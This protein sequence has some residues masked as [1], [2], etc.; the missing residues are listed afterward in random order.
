[1]ARQPGREAEAGDSGDV[2][3]YLRLLE[4]Y[5]QHSDWDEYLALVMSQRFQEDLAAEA[6][7][8]AAIDAAGPLGVLEVALDQAVRLRRIGAAAALT[9]AAARWTRRMSVHTAL[10]AD[11]PHGEA[12]E[13]ELRTGRDVLRALLRAWERYDAGNRGAARALLAAIVRGR[14]PL[15]RTGDGDRWAVPLLR[16]A[17]VIDP[18]AAVL[19]LG[20]VDDNVLGDLARELTAAGDYARARTAGAA[21]RLFFETKAD[22]LADLALAQAEAA[23]KQGTARQQETA[24]GLPLGKPIEPGDRRAVAETANLAADAVRQAQQEE[25]GAS[26]APRVP[27]VAGKLAK[28]AAALTLSGEHALAARRWA[29]AMAAAEQ[30]PDPAEA[31]AEF[32]Q[33]QVRA[34]LLDDA[35]QVIA[36]LLNETDTSWQADAALDPAWQ[37]VTALVA[38]LDPAWQAVTALVAAL[39]ES[40]DVARALTA[41]RMIPDFAHSSPRAVCAVARAIAGTDVA[42]AERLAGLVRD[43]DGR[44]LALASV[45]AA[46]LAAGHQRDAVRVADG[47]EHPGWRAQ[48]LVDLAGAP[49]QAAGIPTGKARDA[50][51]AVTDIEKGAVLLAE[52]AVTQDIGERRRFLAEATRL[53]GKA[54]A[55]ARWRALANIGAIAAQAG[56]TA[57]ARE[58]FTAARRLLARDT[59]EWDFELSQLCRAQ[60]SVGDTTGARETV[61]VTLGALPGPTT[62]RRLWSAVG[63]AITAPASR[64]GR[65]GR[66]SRPRTSVPDPAPDPAIAAAEAAADI[67]IA[68]AALAAIACAIGEAAG[69]AAPGS[70]RAI[71]H[72]ASELDAGDEQAAMAGQVERVLAEAERLAT[73]LRDAGA[74]VADESLAHAYTALG[75]FAAAERRI[76]SLLPPPDPGAEHNAGR[77]SVAADGNVEAEAAGDAHRA[78]P[79]DDCADVD[80]NA[81]GPDEAGDEI[82]LITVALE[83]SSALTD[84]LVAAGEAEHAARFM[85]EVA[86]RLSP[87]A[88]RLGPRGTDMLA[89]LAAAQV[90]AG[91]SEG[92]QTTAAFAATMASATNAAFRL[93]EPLGLP[94]AD[95]TGTVAAVVNEMTALVRDAGVGPADFAGAGQRAGDYARRPWQARAR[96]L[97]ALA[98]T[99]A[100][101]AERARIAA[102]L[103]RE[104]QQIWQLAT[105]TFVRG[106]TLE[107]GDAA[108]ALAA[109]AGAQ[110]RIGE[111]ADA[112]RAIARAREMAADIE[113]SAERAHALAE[114]ALSLSAIGDH[115]AAIST[116]RR[117]D[118]PAY[119]GQAIAAAITAAAKAGV[120]TGSMDLAGEARTIKDEGWRAIALAG[121]ALAGASPLD[122]TEAHELIRQVAH[123]NPRSQAWHEIIGLCLAT[124]RYDLAVGLTDEITDDAGG[125]LAVIAGTLGIRASDAGQPPGGASP[126]Q[127]AA[128]QEAAGDALLRLLPRCARYPE[129]AYAACTALAMAFPADATVIAG[130]VAQHAAAVIAATGDRGRG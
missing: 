88:W 13:A 61:A 21:M 17:L 26:M 65:A 120:A 106:A 51:A 121:V 52:Y 67:P 73:G 19:L 10:R 117:I 4:L 31:L 58:A 80:E 9:L 56:L 96:T 32:A 29:E 43:P 125:H 3:R 128:E 102:L 30:E 1:M 39:A 78:D 92:A 113:H 105:V 44:G 114:V 48:A 71:V 15:I 5:K 95:E 18:G 94:M 84:A 59:R 46:A 27:R 68:V 40:G 60:L 110:A 119:Q 49:E 85:R 118:H 23:L 36:V 79:G 97:A 99:R 54:P 16:Q 37:G 20:L 50:I 90:R 82:R 76:L 2:S 127:N 63:A 104:Q 6:V 98:R 129:A 108:C 72:Q 75:H 111:L 116:A 64:R 83:C 107:P 86:D 69:S 103:A 8:T 24:V 22:V 70:A 130:A 112:R 74:I 100:D 124:G 115:A 33:A 62:A 11:E 91:D 14:P 109:L 45:A 35:A 25:P 122:F 7:R 87:C 12:A 55:D 81:T 28:A 101:P 89:E 34:G 47:I 57:D 77:E 126:P 53:A 38:A 42:E 66:P 93:P 41:L 123:G